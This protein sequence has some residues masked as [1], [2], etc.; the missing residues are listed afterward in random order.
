MEIKDRILLDKADCDSSP[1]HHVKENAGLPVRTFR[2]AD[3]IQTQCIRLGKRQQKRAD[4]TVLVRK[5]FRFATDI[6][7]KVGYGP[8]YYS[9]VHELAGNA[10]LKK[11]FIQDGLRATTVTQ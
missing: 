8:Q 9:K 6:G 1:D 7:A 11:E 2:K 4:Q 10:S 3:P 5:V